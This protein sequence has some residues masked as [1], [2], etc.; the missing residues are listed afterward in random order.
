M[1]ITS[2]LFTVCGCST[3]VFPRRNATDPET[4][5]EPQSLGK[6][7]RRGEE[8]CRDAHPVRYIRISHSYNPETRSSYCSSNPISPSPN[9]SQN[10]FSKSPPSAAL[11]YTSSKYSF[12]AR[13][14]KQARRTP[15]HSSIVHIPSDTPTLSPHIRT[16]LQTRTPS[17]ESITPNHDLRS[18]HICHKSPVRW[19]DLDN[20]TECREC[21]KRVC[22]V[23]TRTCVQPGCERKVCSRCCDEVGEEGEPWC[24]GC[25]KERNET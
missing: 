22:H 21:E 7:K 11:Q 20:Y 23:C 2:D 6:R 13:P 12:D 3:E 17:S 8:E 4:Q 24:F 15:H 9:K 16:H 14:I 1:Y 10:R 5:S 19:R 25:L 18:C